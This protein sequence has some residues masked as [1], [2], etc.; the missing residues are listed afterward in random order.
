MSYLEATL[1]TVTS[2]RRRHPRHYDRR[3][4]HPMGF[5]QNIAGA[6]DGSM[7]STGA[8]ANALNIL[9]TTTIAA[10]NLDNNGTLNGTDH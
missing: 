9:G 7:T 6:A 5:I 10:A 1:R 3:P 2:F 8:V 4:G